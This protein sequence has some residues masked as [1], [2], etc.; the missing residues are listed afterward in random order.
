MTENQENDAQKRIVVDFTDTAELELE[1]LDIGVADAVISFDISGRISNLPE[2]RLEE[3]AG[4]ELRPAEL[5][6]TVVDAS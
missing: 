4:G 3:L 1:S 6:L 2:D 5:H